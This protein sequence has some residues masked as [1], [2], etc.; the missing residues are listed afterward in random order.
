MRRV[1]YDS[2]FL[3]QYSPRPGAR[4]ADWPDSVPAEEKA[5]R[6]TILIEEQKEASLEI[7]LESV[8]ADVEVLVEGPAKR[9]PETWF[10]K[11]PQFKTVVFPHRGERSGDRVRLRVAAASPYTLFG[12][13]VPTRVRALEDVTA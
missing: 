9:N 5:R 11:T 10:G 1:R 13:G 8:G 2:A 12:E 7:N 6:I 4:S 3:F